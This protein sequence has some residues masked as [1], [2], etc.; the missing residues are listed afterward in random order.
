MAHAVGICHDTTEVK[1]SFPVHAATRLFLTRSESGFTRSYP[2][3]TVLLARCNALTRSRQTPVA[4]RSIVLVYMHSLARSTM[5]RSS[6]TSTSS[7]TASTW[8]WSNAS[9]SEPASPRARAAAQATSA[10]RP[11][12]VSTGVPGCASR[13][14]HDSALDS[15]A[16][17]EA[18]QP[19]RVGAR[20]RP[21]ASY[22][23]AESNQLSGNSQTPV[24]SADRPSLRRL[25][26]R[27]LLLARRRLLAHRR[28]RSRRRAAAPAPPPR[29]LAGSRSGA[30]GCVQESQ[31]GE[32]SCD[33]LKLQRATSG[34]LALYSA[35][36]PAQ[37][38]GES[39]H[40][41]RKQQKSERGPFLRGR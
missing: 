15:R 22:F 37:V 19:A 21:D 35:S 25:L 6:G 29:G 39:P 11:R 14:Q 28:C 33:F 20:A 23:P 17:R 41:N 12:R 13:H 4:A 31:R 32:S 9:P 40:R 26:L 5:V 24:A 8:T 38:R 27:A 36:H 3:V 34:G 16:W 7:S 30:I 18:S 1:D 2:T 10:R